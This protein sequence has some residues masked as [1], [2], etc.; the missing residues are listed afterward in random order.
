MITTTTATNEPTIGIK[1]NKNIINTD[2][3]M[4]L[5]PNSKST[6]KR[7]VYNFGNKFDKCRFNVR[8]S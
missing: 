6:T 5:A 3:E 4:K 7:Y 8:S 1:F 2:I